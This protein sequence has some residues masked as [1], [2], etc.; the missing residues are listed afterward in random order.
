[1][2]DRRE[3]RWFGQEI[4]MDNNKKPRHLWERRVGGDVEK[5]R[6]E[7]RMGRDYM[8]ADVGKMEDLLLVDWAGEDR[9]M[10]WTSLMEPDV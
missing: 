3:L 1:M 8:K 4:R 5:R 9:N 7:V 10:L 6:G 2:V